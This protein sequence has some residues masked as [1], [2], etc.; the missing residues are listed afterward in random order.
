MAVKWWADEDV[1]AAYPW[2][3]PFILD[4]MKAGGGVASE[5]ALCDAR[6]I[7]AAGLDGVFG[8]QGRAILDKF[9]EVELV[10]ETGGGYAAR[11]WSEYQREDEAKKERQRRWREKRKAGDASE[12]SRD[13]SE[14]SPRRRDDVVATATVHDSTQQYR[15]VLMEVVDTASRARVESP[16]VPMMPIPTEESPSTGIADVSEAFRRTQSGRQSMMLAPATVAV[17]AEMVKA[18]GPATVIEAIRRASERIQGDLTIAYLRPVVASVAA[19]EPERRPKHGEPG[20]YQSA[21][22]KSAN[23]VATPRRVPDGEL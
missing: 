21:A 22:Y 15:T 16:P 10:V 18:H 13:V 8:D 1:E 6:L 17:L 12:A 3:W 19:G 23:G 2:A 9:L 7:R 4:A 14:T 11:S 20:K 5:R